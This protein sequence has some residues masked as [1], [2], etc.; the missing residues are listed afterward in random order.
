MKDYVQEIDKC[1]R[2]YLT[3]ELR[4]P[5]E[6]RMVD[7]YAAK[8][9][10]DSELFYGAWYER[11]APGAFDD[12]LGDDSV[13]LFNHDPNLILARNKV[14]MT[15]TQDETGL[16]YQFEAPNTTAGND[17][18]ENL[19]NG[20]V[21]SSSFAFTVKSEEWTYS[22]DKSKPSV[23]TIKK[24]ERLYDVSPVTYPAYPDTSVGRRAF[25]GI[26]NELEAKHKAEQ[27]RTIKMFQIQHEIFLLKQSTK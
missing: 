23:R 11:I 5:K 9:N 25:D 15:I 27:D 18:L 21:R 22:E 10:T 19:K 24:I 12:V 6:G 2:R 3:V 13:A 14:T 7:G 8:F 20:N 1:E 26:K 4:A 16:R 17:L